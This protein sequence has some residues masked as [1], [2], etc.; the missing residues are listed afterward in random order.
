MDTLLNFHFLLSTT[1]VATH[2][3]DRLK[4]L[5]LCSKS[6]GCLGKYI[7]CLCGKLSGTEVVNSLTLGQDRRCCKWV[8]QIWFCYRSKDHV[9]NASKMPKLETSES[10]VRKGLCIER[11]YALELPQIHLKKAR[12]SGFFYAKGRENGRGCL[13]KISSPKRNSWRD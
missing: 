10:G 13:H 4:P 2:S 7:Q 9:P 1:I 11:V 6:W 3:C 8:C 5:W 12:S